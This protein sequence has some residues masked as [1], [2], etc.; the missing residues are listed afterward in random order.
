MPNPAEAKTL[1]GHCPHIIGLCERV[2]SND[3][4]TARTGEQPTRM[5]MMIIIM[6][7]MMIV[8]MCIMLI[9]TMMGWQEVSQTA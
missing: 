7:L 8:M 2:G 3:I 6:M 4:G 5:M 1:T 9:M